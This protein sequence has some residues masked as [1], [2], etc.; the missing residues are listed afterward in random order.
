MKNFTHKVLI[1][2]KRSYSK[3]EELGSAAAWAIRN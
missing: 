3:L 1:C 2:I